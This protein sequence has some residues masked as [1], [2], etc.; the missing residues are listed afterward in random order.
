MLDIKFIREHA[1]LIKEG[2]RKKRISIDLDRLLALD[3][4]RRKLLAEVESLRAEKNRRSKE[5]PALP[6]GERE[7][8]VAEMRY[9]T[10]R[11]KELEQALR[12]VETEYTALMLRVPNVP[13]AEVPEGETSEDNVEIKRWGEIPQFDFLPR[14]HVELGELLDII[15]IPRGVKVAG[16]RNYFLKNE[17]VLLELAVLRF[18]LDHMIK[19]GF[20]PLLVPHLV[21]D[22]M[23]VGT[24]YYPGGEEQAYR[25]EKDGLSLIGTSEVPVTA[26]HADEVL[27]EDE[28]P[29]YYTALSSC[30]RREA[31]TY[32]RDTRGLFRI[33]Q[34]QKVEQ[35]VLCQNDAEISWQEHLHIL[36]NAE[37]VVQALGLPYRVV[38]VCGGDLGQPQVQKFDIETWMPSRN[39]YAETHSASRFHDFQARRLHLRYRTR[40]GKTE[41]VHT[42]NNTVIASPRILIPILELNQEPDGSVRIPEVLRPYMHGQEKIVPKRKPGRGKK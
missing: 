20:T 12:P 5:I 21:R 32:G 26:Y 11:T 6:P 38:N 7:K 24:A 27:S 16:T 9:L 18:A 28:L 23:M 33:H 41:Y 15:D 39:S 29:K 35:V 10:E 2:A 14:D 17:G 30:Y 37:E 40:Q 34:F 36:Q 13:A 4:K 3:E 19:K 1:D 22:E 42:L 31:G 25:L 8:A